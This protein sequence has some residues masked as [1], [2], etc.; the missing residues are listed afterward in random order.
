MIELYESA[1]LRN[2]ADRTWRDTCHRPRQRRPIN[3]PQSCGAR[4]SINT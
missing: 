2:R 4:P 1:V 3:R